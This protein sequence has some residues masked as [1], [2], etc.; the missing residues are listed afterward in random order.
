MSK[1]L[2][3]DEKALSS[4]KSGVKMLARAVKATLGPKGR[5]VVMQRGGMEPPVST[6]DGVTVAKEISLKDPFENMGAQL[7]KE[8]ASKT[9]D[10]AGDG[11]TTAIVL[12]DAIFSEGVKSV[13]A[14]F[15][16]MELKKGIDKGVSVVL[17]ALTELAIEVKTGEE[18]KQ[19][20]SISSNNDV[21]I[22]SIIAEAMQ[23]VGKDGIV[24]IAE[25]KGVD[26][27]LKVVEGM[28]FDKG[29][30]SPYF[31]TNPEKM[32][33][34]L[35]NCHILLVDSKISS[36]KDL[37]PILEPIA[38]SGKSLLVIAEDVDSEALAVLVL[39]KLKAGL[40][41]CAVKAPFFGDRKKEVLKDIAILTGATCISEDVGL[42]LENAQIEHLGLA[43]KIKVA[44]D[45]TTIIEG[46]GKKKE[47]EK[48]IHAIKAEI[49]NATS[50][51]DREKLEERLA[52]FI[53]GVAVINVGA[54]TETEMKEKKYRVEDALHATRAAIAQGIVPGGGIALIRASAALDKLELPLEE[55]A[56]RDILK[57]ALFSPTMAIAENCGKN[58]EVVVDKILSSD[59]KSYGYNGL[60]DSFGDLVQEGVVDPA[61]VTKTALINAASIAGLLLTASA[62]IANKPEKK[63]DAQQMPGGGM[64]MGG[65][66]GMMGGMPGMGMM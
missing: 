49:K 66:P 6:K 22:G 17:R 46:Q 45:A 30:I 61:F 29:Y 56:G 51:Y 50:D 36:A 7:L 33:V 58:G 19:V 12:A 37:V 53:G 23:K 65:M 63:K 40:S 26:T 43:K 18:I 62:M 9:A 15:N 57:R 34:E 54:A 27:T 44:K 24:S 5:N 14:G 55:S 28:E 25:A 39:N 48:R 8:A 3:F 2:R 21:E 35:E 52:R 41:V 13:S 4:L 60:K 42:K 64:G 47:I 38:Q 1:L 59:F 31:V 11:T 10:V 32:I 20:A 16:P